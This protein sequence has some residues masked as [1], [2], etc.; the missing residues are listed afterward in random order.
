M[1]YLDHLTHYEEFIISLLYIIATINFFRNSALHAASTRA[2]MLRQLI[3][4]NILVILLDITI[5]G[6][7]FADLYKL[8]TAY[9]A[10]S[11]S[12]KLKLEFSILN[13]L[14]NLT[15]DRA[16]SS[17]FSGGGDHI[18]DGSRRT[19]LST[20]L[21]VTSTRDVGGANRSEGRR[22]RGSFQ[23]VAEYFACARRASRDQSPPE[24]VIVRTTDMN[25]VHQDASERPMGPLGETAP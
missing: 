9:K 20:T 17:S 7:E 6:L 16:S 23:A 5:L 22:K 2:R 8:Q 3:T 14:V 4:I 11:Y 15:R 13:S 24:G 18:F 1:S 19:N 25:I 10:M 12:I 21:N